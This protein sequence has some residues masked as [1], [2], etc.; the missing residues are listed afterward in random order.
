MKCPY[1]GEQL[2]MYEVP[3]EFIDDDTLEAHE[4]YACYNCDKTF[5]RNVTYTVT[6]RGAL[7]E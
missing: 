5:W 7:E 4:H 3:T 6:K 1:C 2:D